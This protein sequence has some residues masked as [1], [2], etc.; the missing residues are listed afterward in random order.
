MADGSPTNYQSDVIGRTLT[1][2]EFVEAVYR[3]L[4]SASESSSR[5]ADARP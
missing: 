4:R 5:E 1:K 3:S 2:A